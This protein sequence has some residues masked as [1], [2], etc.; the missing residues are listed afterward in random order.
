[1]SMKTRTFFHILL[2]GLACW[3][4]ISFFH[5][6]EQIAGILKTGGADLHV[7]LNLIP[8]LL[9][10]FVLAIYS[11]LE[12]RGNSRRHSLLLIPDEF[13]EQDEREQ[14]ITAKACRTSYI[15][16]YVAMPAAALLLIF[17]PFF[18][19]KMPYFPIIVI[20]VLITIQHLSY[21]LSFHKHK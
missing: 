6:A 5:A 18:Q 10:V 11:Y 17:Y 8:I 15:V 16:L 20:F 2:F 14:M 1:M 3:T 21:M 7:V 13:K 12:K 9:F 19:A 4:F